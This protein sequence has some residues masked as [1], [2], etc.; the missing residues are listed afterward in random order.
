MTA[1]PALLRVLIAVA[2]TA[3]PN[4]LLAQDPA[5][6]PPAGGAQE[7]FY[8]ISF[9]PE[10]ISL[11]EAI[12]LASKFT[13]KP[14]HYKDSEFR[15]KPK[16]MMTGVVRVPKTRIYEFW[17]AIFVTQQFAM[18][19]MGPGDGDFVVVESIT[20]SQM[21][22]Q[23][24]G[25]VPEERLREV[26]AK[27]GEVIMT[28]ISLKY[29]KV[30]NVRSAMTQILTNRQSE[31][32]AEVPS[33]NAIVVI[34]FAP[35]VYALYQ[36]LKAMD[37][38][39]AATTLKFEIIKLKFAVAEELQPIIADLIQT[40]AGGAG[41][42]G[43]G[44]PRGV[45]PGEQPLAP[46]QERIEPKIIADGRTNALVIY[47][48]ENDLAEIRR[49]VDALDQQVTGADSDIRIYFLKNTNAS[50]MEQVLRDLFQQGS[51]RSG[52][53]GGIRP[54]GGGQPGG[55]GPV[56]I[57]GESGQD[58]VIVADE[59]TNALLITC[60]RT[61]YEQIEPIIDQLDKRRPQVLVHAAIAELSNTDLR[62]IATE[63]TAIEG[64]D[65]RYRG[66]AATGFGL[67]TI[68][69]ASSIGGTGGTGTT[70][71][72]TGTGTGG[73]TPTTSGSGSTGTNGFEGL[74][75]IPFLTDGGISFTGLVAGIFEKN[76]NVPLL[77]ALLQSTTRSNLL[78]NASVLTNDNEESR[79][80]V[81]R[82]VPTST[83][84]LDPSGASRSGFGQYEEA[85]LE[86]RISPHIS[87]DNYLRL[88]IELIVDAFVGA[89]N[90]TSGIPPPK[91]TR[92][93]VGNV[94]VP[95][96]KTVVIGGLIQDNATETIDKVPFLGDIPVLGELFKSRSNSVEKT[97]LYL[98]VTPTIFT[99]FKTL[100]EISYQRKLEIQKLEGNVRLVDPNFRTVGIEDIRVDLEQV[101]RS[102][103]L[104]L[105]RYVPVIPQGE[106]SARKDVD[107]IP[108]TPQ[109]LPGDS[110]I[111]IQQGGTLRFRD[112]KAVRDPKPPPPAGTGGEGK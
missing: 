7:D 74:A 45:Q 29:V 70:T 1:H 81:G 80:K 27:A 40:G 67:T 94:T 54:G 73:G 8:D 30:E 32:Q 24:A 18:I 6:A 49:L 68:T 108:V 103:N 55:Q 33:A 104:D 59:N 97:N 57:G 20:N 48:M 100:E 106:D 2:L 76:L 42:P 9:T 34:G 58:I 111:E 71:G 16:I 22:R 35:T 41:G 89:V 64:G 82:E 4:R 75:R 19:P 12:Q 14:F 23:R 56:T 90:L 110:K 65:D 52:R 78:S 105:P 38:P 31:L 77:V 85:N 96:G 72:G 28:T 17:Q 15:G 84:Q 46:G 69:T 91:T 95:N 93:F 66:A 3:I 36:I 92:E 83:N 39:T 61:K 112:G 62:N 5:V 37:Q 107:G 51:S 86:L 10:G 88:E 99:E 26:A 109:A 53:A 13:G 44:I 79:I 87:N 101:E 43:R 21:I 11:E 63:L 102:G 25:Y 50:D 47:A 60:S 98:F